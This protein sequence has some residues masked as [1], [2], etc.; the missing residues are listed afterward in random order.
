MTNGVILVMK[1]MACLVFAAVLALSLSGCFAEAI[2]DALEGNASGAVRPG[3][4]SPAPGSDV[5]QSG[6]DASPKASDTPAPGSALGDLLG[7]DSSWDKAVF[8]DLPEPEFEHSMAAVNTSD[9][10]QM[11]GFTCNKGQFE[12]YVKV[13]EKAGFQSEKGI[14]DRFGDPTFEAYKDGNYVE[15]VFQGEGGIIKYMANV[16]DTSEWPS[17]DW[18]DM[19]VPNASLHTYQDLGNG[20]FFISTNYWSVEAFK[21]Y[22]EAC[23]AAGFNQDVTE[24]ADDYEMWFYAV[25]QAGDTLNIQLIID[26]PERPSGNIGIEKAQ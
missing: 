10:Q 7:G 25:N 26:K 21:E 2:N 15:I 18:P 19:P 12:A 5:I 23:K 16:I 3:E 8:G 6:D 11:A 9:T 13:V 24:G 22:C 17:K 20:S 14:E 4:T 1:R